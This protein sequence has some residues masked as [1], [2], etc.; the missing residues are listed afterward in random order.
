MTTK[1]RERD[2]RKRER[3][4][5]PGKGRIDV[6]QLLRAVQN[7]VEDAEAILARTEHAET[8]SP[9]EAWNEAC[10]GVEQLE[11]LRT[12]G[13]LQPNQAERFAGFLRR[14]ERLLPKLRQ[15]DWREPRIGWT[16]L[17]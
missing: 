6:S 8:L 11:E 15:R 14:I 3:R 4:A 2:A 9:N 17:L 7:G 13:A 10:Y 16:D 5:P 1:Q 12:A